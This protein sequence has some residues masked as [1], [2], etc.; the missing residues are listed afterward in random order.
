MSKLAKSTERILSEDALKH[1][2]KCEQAGHRPS[3]ESVAGALQIS[4]DNAA[5]L[6]AKMAARHLLELR[7]DIFHLTSEGQDYALQVIRAHRLW[8]RYLADETGFAEAEW[9]ERAERR[10]HSLSM[11]EMEALAAQLGH[12]THDPHGDPIPT[13]NGSMVS[14]GGHPMAHLKVGQAGRIVHLE[15]EPE[16]VYAQLVAEGLHPGLLVRISEVSPQRIRFWADG[17]EHRL[18]P[19]LAANISVVMV[20]PE[21]VVAAEPHETLSDLKPGQTARVLNL[22]RAC[23]GSERR[24]LMDLGILPGTAIK[25]EM[26]SPSGDPTAYRI[27]G[28][29]IAL[30][31]EQADFINI[32]REMEIAN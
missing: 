23:R 8:E 25:A 29:L 6:L 9:H 2:Y 10:E 18:A 26:V 22:S 16:V 1:I 32:S 21:E 20:D 7:G 14:H 27:R 13:A 24:R 19:M 15:D 5:S 12:P 11:A 31:Q 3:M 17:T 4:L 30:R 28:A